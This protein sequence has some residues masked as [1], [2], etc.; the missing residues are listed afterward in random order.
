MHKNVPKI[1]IAR[2]NFFVSFI[3]YTYLLGYK[4]CPSPAVLIIHESLG[5]GGIKLPLYI[6]CD[7]SV[8][9]R[10]S[11]VKFCIAANEHLVNICANFCC[12]A[13]KMSYSDVT[14]SNY[15]GK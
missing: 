1:D 10:D 6:C 3:R 2:N 13:A 12:P 4:I 5:G 11:C 15:Y 7:I 8:T 9:R 14:K